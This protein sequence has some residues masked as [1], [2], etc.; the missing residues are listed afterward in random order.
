M[1]RPQ[2]LLHWLDRWQQ[3]RRLPGFIYAVIK[4]YGEDQA[5]YQAA[6]LTYY[7]FLSL[8]PLLLILTT[9]AN[10]LLS[11]YPELEAKVV[12][13]LTGYF[14][15]LGNQLATRIHGLHAGGFA[16]I[17]GL[18]FAFYGT[19]GVADV[20]RRGVQ[21]IWGVPEKQ[22]AGFPKSLLLSFGLIIVGGIGFI[23]ASILAG[24]A[25][26]AGHG[27][28]FR[29]LSTAITLVILFVLYVCL[30]DF[31]LPV[32]VTL[33]QTWLGAATAAIGLV[34]LQ[35]VGG[36]LVARELK[37]L[38]ALY[39]YFAIPLGLLFWIYLQAQL[40][41]YAIEIAVVKSKKLWPRSLSET[42]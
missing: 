4:K 2:K 7:G 29:L 8:F 42:N 40:L 34:I 11:G 18:L 1:N 6:L 15:L 10:N 36:Y 39:S 21:D 32:H 19:H 37:N 27:L 24:V 13:G 41:Y 25:S 23:T 17:A 28:A 3:R 14:P 22:R 38:D 9:L 16:L 12:R 5:G 26:A 35:S 30:L 31:C 33:K 20:F